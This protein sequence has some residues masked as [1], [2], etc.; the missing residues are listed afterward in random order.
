MRYLIAFLVCLV[1]IASVDAI[2]IQNNSGF[3]R[4]RDFEG[5]FRQW[6]TK[7]EKSYADDSE[8]YL[9]L[10]HYIKNL[11]T[12]ADY[13]KKH[14]GM[15]KFAPNKFSDL[16]IEEFRAGYLNYV[17]NKLIKDRST[18]QNFDYPANIP[19]SLD[20]RQKGFVTPVKNQEQ[21]GSCW[22]FSAGEQIETAYIMAGNAA[23]NVSEQQI[24]D[25]DP[26][27]GGCGG[28]DPMTAYQYVQSAGGIT[29]NTDYPYT[30]TDGTCYAQN[31]PKFTQIASYGYASNK[32]NETELKQAIAAR[33]PLSI[34]VDAETWMNYQSG[35][36]NSNCPDELDH[37]VQIVGYDVEQSTN[38]PYY[39]VRNSWG[40]DWGME[41]YILVGEG[42]NLCGITDEVT[43]V[44]VEAV[45][46]F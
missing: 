1:A 16:S 44:E 40:T 6:M 34:C 38:T 35:V 26:Y 11:R 33:G 13:N 19:V 31:T 46:T 2:R 25:C 29:T 7:H 43:Y 39:I 5:E 27:D 17:P 32:G 20:W 22:A 28:G 42:Q 24:V 12:V 9:R 41:G 15:A 10:S 18:K 8:Y 45:P 36:L 3:H 4:A 37:C 14:A 21:C 30:A 23:Q